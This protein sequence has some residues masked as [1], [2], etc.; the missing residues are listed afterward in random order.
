MN[1]TDVDLDKR[2]KMH[3]AKMAVSALPFGLVWDSSAK[4]LEN[5]L[6][7]RGIK[8]PYKLFY[9]YKMPGGKTQSEFQNVL[10]M[11]EF[12]TNFYSNYAAKLLVDK[13]LSM[14]DKAKIFKYVWRMRKKYVAKSKQY[15]SEIRKLNPELA[16]IKT[17]HPYSIVFG[18][19]FGFAPDEI[20]YFAD[21]DNRDFHFEQEM[22]KVFDEKYGI[23]VSYILAP[24]TAK[25]IIAVLNQN[26]LYNARES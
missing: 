11:T 3:I 7:V 16:N 24:N 8:L 17:Y 6:L 1:K 10:I 5:D 4:N 23:R 19:T 14:S 15:E 18:A 2:L 26:V 22:F 13:N 12:F 25:K 9:E 20:A 21:A